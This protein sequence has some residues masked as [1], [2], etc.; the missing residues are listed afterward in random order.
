MRPTSQEQK[1]GLEGASY[2]EWRLL[3]EVESTPELSQ[4]RLAYKLG[5]A[6]GVAN[7]LIRNLVRRGYIR[8]S[9]VG[10]KR[11]VYVLT[12]AGVARKVHLT[13]AYVDR[14]LDHYRRVRTL[15][16]EDM[17][18]LTISS[19]SR[20]AI[21]GTSEMAELIYLALRD[22]GI[23]SIEFFD[24]DGSTTELL[25]TPVRGL[26]SIAPGDYAK[27]MVAFSV[28]IE[29]RCEELFSRGVSD[30]QIVTPLQN[31]RGE[32]SKASSRETA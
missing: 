23:A 16:R 21:Y 5:I 18:T 4:R 10:W 1:S 32:P 8:A 6:L 27:V 19:E 22:M 26:D 2:R 29:E 13:V 11:W 7:L 12:P 17:E 15:L 28:G 9:R 25:G 30:S 24:H 3:E 31:P 20:I 14:F